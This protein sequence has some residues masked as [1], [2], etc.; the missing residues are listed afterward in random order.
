MPA[1][2]TGAGIAM[3]KCPACCDE[4]MQC[5]GLPG[6]CAAENSGKGAAAS[7]MASQKDSNWRKDRLMD[8]SEITRKTQV[9]QAA[10]TVTRL[11]IGRLR[12]LLEEHGYR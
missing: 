6:V 4:V 10:T 9:L 5:A 2:C 7:A 12:T 3:G 1:V 11:C 8:S